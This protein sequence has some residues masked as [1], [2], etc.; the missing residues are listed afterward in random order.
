MAEII[1][2]PLRRKLFRPAPQ[3]G[4]VVRIMPSDCGWLVVS[5]NHSWAFGARSEAV[6]FA[7]EIADG[8]GVS[9]VVQMRGSA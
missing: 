7:R 3:P 5:R 2:F 9:T 6:V 1:A 8:F 4:F